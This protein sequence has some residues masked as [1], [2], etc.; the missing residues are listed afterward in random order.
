LNIQ[1]IR[2]YDPNLSK[3][4]LLYNS[5]EKNSV[6]KM[7]ELATL[8]PTLGIEL[9]ALEIDP[10]NGAAP[11]PDQIP[12]RLRELRDKGVKWVYLGSS[13]F[14]NSNGKIFTE[15]AT[16]N[17]IAVVSPYPALVKDHEA[18]L[19]IAA[20]REEVGA[21]AAEQAL[22]VLR[23]GAVP[24]NLPISVAT[25]FTY[26]VNMKVAKQLN[27]KPPAAFSKDTEYV[28]DFFLPTK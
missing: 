21:L 7:K 27:L 12:V 24:E 5:N 28:Q 18:L 3:L 20:P 16:E 1:V 11:N 15:S 14:L 9:V 6:Q 8:A 23:D 10:N 13:S 4:G 25:H 26:V 17:G 2:Q 19:S 22:K